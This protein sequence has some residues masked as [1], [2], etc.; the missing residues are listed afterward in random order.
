M[1]LS[2]MSLG[3]GTPPALGWGEDTV[4]VGTEGGLVSTGCPGAGLRASDSC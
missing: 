1:V 2:A 3:L 4:G